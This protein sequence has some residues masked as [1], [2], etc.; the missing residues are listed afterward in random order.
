MVRDSAQAG[1][2]KRIGRPPVAALSV[3]VSVRIAADDYDRL[4]RIA[5]KH[6]TSV[7]DVIRRRLSASKSQTA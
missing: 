4:D 7:P 2:M 1:P 3:R 6:S 5:R